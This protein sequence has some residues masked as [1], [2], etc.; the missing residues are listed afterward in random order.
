MVIPLNKHSRRGNPIKN[1][2]IKIIDPHLHLFNL[3]EGDY[4]WLKPENPPHWPNK[5]LINRDYRESDIALQTPLELTGFVHV[6]AGFD[7]QQPWREIDWLEQHCRKPFRSVAFVNLN[8]SANNFTRHI[9]LLCQRPSVR[10][11]RHILDEDA[12]TLLNDPKVVGHFKVLQAHNLS[13]D[14][15]LSV[16]DGAAVCGLINILEQT[17]ELRVII[18]HAGWVPSFNDK[19]Q[20]QRWTDNLKRLARY[21][22]VAIKLSGWEMAN[23]NWTNDDVKPVLELCLELFS[24]RCVML[25]SNFPLCSWSYSLQDLWLNYVQL[26]GADGSL[27]THLSSGNAATW[28]QF[29]EF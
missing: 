21:P 2:P 8:L 11:V 1:S 4:A 13:F 12:E 16:V 19:E 10:G 28:Y 14:A 6:E 25:A 7:N 26:I 20:W 5:Q 27:L 29:D 15:Q 17:P 24:D 9:E 18:D 22:Q 23:S 3:Q